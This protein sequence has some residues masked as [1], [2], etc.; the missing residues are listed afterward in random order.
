[1]NLWNTFLLEVIIPPSNHCICSMMTLKIGDEVTSMGRD[2]KKTKIKMPVINNE[3]FQ[4]ITS[5][6]KLAAT[7][8]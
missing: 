4:K 8:V 7:Y 2:G 1:V 3:M 6:K 5:E